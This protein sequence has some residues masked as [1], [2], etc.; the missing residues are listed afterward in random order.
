MKLSY[1]SLAAFVAH[2]RILKHA[3][4]LTE[5]EQV[6]LA[7]MTKLVESMTPADRATLESDNAAT[8]R[9][10]ERALRNL[11]QILAAHGVLSG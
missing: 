9:R 4:N 11:H 6:R 10:S 1:S 7:E 2:Y 5:D 3:P 8:D